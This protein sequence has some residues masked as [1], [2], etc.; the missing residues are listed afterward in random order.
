MADMFA[1]D[2]SYYQ[3]RAEAEVELAV[4]STDTRVVQA[5]YDLS[6]A[7]LELAYGCIDQAKRAGAEVSPR[8]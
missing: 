8:G 5:H 1:D 2:L 4:H 7:Y 6:A 3:M